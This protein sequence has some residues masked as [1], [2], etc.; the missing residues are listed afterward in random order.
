LGQPLPP[1]HHDDLPKLQL[2]RNLDPETV[3]VLAGVARELAARKDGE[4]AP[5]A[6]DVAYLELFSSVASFSYDGVRTS[7]SS[8][9]CLLQIAAMAVEQANCIARCAETGGR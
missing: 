5:R 6:S 1:H 3:Q 2:A 8:F 9:A 4:C 7:A